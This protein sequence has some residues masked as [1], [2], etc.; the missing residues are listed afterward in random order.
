MPGL[1]R[2]VSGTC[3]AST[4]P[5]CWGHLCRL[6][7]TL[8]RVLGRVWRVPVA[9]TGSDGRHEWRGHGQSTRAVTEAQLEMPSDRLTRRECSGCTAHWRSTARIYYAAPNISSSWTPR[10]RTLPPPI[11]SIPAQS[12]GLAPRRCAERRRRARPLAD[13]PRKP[14]SGARC[15][16]PSRPTR[17]RRPSGMATRRGTRELR[18]SR[19]WPMEHCTKLE[20]KMRV[21]VTPDEARTERQHEPA[22]NSRREAFHLSC[23]HSHHSASSHWLQYRRSMLPGCLMM[24]RTSVASFPTTAV[25][26]TTSGSR[27]L[28]PRWL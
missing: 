25:L 27:I 6:V 8:R 5:L 2:A 12:S 20:T 28:V 23:W 15:S 13:P 4:K 19:K 10:P 17:H 26:P 7:G 22:T 16:A 11:F 18:P 21:S 9:P 3:H 14:R 1:V 24:F